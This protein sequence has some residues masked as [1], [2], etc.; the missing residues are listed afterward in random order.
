VSPCWNDLRAVT[1]KRR[2]PQA[3][4]GRSVTCTSIGRGLWP[5]SK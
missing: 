2:D 1:K 4:P 3:D 5:W